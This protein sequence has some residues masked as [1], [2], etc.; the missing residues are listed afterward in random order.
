VK[1]IFLSKTLNML[2]VAALISVFA[3]SPAAL[4][5]KKRPKGPPPIPVSDP[6][7]TYI[8]SYSSNNYLHEVSLN[9]SEGYIRSYKLGDSSYTDI[10]V[11]GTYLYT[12][13]DHM[14]VGGHAGLKSY[15]NGTSSSSFMILMGM[16]TYNLDSDFKNSY[17]GEAALGL[18]PAYKK[19]E[20]KFASDVSFFFDV[21]KR[22]A[23][24]DHVTY[25]PLFRLAKYGA[26]DMEFLIQALNVSLMF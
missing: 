21:G 25:R 3:V 17:F 12:L 15:Q 6:S 11:N 14:Q 24:W 18:A 9:L 5:Q 7:S 13:R 22:F 8:S 4:A 23:L 26:Q 10:N 20:G 2:G 1:N 19:T 16:F